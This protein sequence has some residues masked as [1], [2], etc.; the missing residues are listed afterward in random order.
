MVAGRG[1]GREEEKVGG[2]TV[3]GGVV[4]GPEGMTCA[5]LSLCV[6]GRSSRSMIP[7][8]IT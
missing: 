7:A 4:Q 1:G 5:L 2:Y 3:R 8:K 6:G